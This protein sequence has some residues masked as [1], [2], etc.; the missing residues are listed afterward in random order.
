MARHIS[1]AGPRS[2]DTI[3]KMRPMP[4]H[5]AYKLIGDA[6]GRFTQIECRETPIQGALFCHGTVRALV[7]EAN[8]CSYPGGFEQLDESTRKSLLRV[9]HTRRL[10]RDNSRRL[11]R[12][13][14]EHDPY[15][16]LLP[17]FEEVHPIQAIVISPV[18]Q[19]VVPIWEHTL[20]PVRPFFQIVLRVSAETVCGRTRAMLRMK[21]AFID[22]TVY[23]TQNIRV[24]HGRDGLE[25][26]EHGS[27]HPLVRLSDF[28]LTLDISLSGASQPFIRTVELDLGHKQRELSYAPD[29]IRIGNVE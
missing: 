22:L 23:G 25:T 12:L 28:L 20:E 13:R 4:K 10:N 29:G 2:I 6:I 5:T 1:F 16:S 24:Q 15:R 7:R 17:G 8:H 18:G 9:L 21:S 26:A 3:R 14:D 27:S 11:Q 19:G